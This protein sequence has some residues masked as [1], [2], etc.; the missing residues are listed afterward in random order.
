MDPR[1]HDYYVYATRP[2]IVRRGP[3]TAA[4]HR[5]RR[6]RRPGRLRRGAARGLVRVAGWLDAVPRP[7]DRAAPPAP[8][9]SP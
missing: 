3:G 7:D 8:R 9:S 1:A 5:V 6:I 4:H 2:L